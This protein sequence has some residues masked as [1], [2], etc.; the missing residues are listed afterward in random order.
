VTE[1]F[2]RGSSNS[3]EQTFTAV[4][5]VFIGAL[6]IPQKEWPPAYGWQAKKHQKH[7]ISS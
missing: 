2:D 6:L 4:V 1:P 7:K 3:V 5:D